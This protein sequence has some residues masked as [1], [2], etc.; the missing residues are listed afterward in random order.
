MLR[1]DAKTQNFTSVWF[2]VTINGKES[3]SIIDT[4]A[5]A[6]NVIPLEIATELGLKPTFNGRSVTTIG[7]ETVPISEPLTL[8]FEINGYQQRQTFVVSDASFDFILMGMPFA[9]TL[10][11]VN[12]KNKTI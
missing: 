9:S 11:S 8:D 12:F 7:K 2:K 1:I 6:H 10:T 5:S 4:G 3:H